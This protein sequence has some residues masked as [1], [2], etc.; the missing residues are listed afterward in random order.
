MEVVQLYLNLD[1]LKVFYLIGAILALTIAILA[2][3]TL[4]ER[5]KNSKRKSSRR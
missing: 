5:A 2:Y 4:S 1:W 3:P